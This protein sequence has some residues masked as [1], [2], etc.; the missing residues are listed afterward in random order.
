MQVGD[1]FT[2]G[3]IPEYTYNPRKSFRLEDQIRDYLATGGSVLVITGN[4]KS[5]KSVLCDKVVGENCVNIA[6]G[7]IQKVGDIWQSIVHEMG[8]S[9]NLTI[10]QSQKT[11]KTIDVTGQ[12]G[13][14]FGIKLGTESKS[15][16][17]Q[18]IETA[19]SEEKPISVQRQA[20][21]GL[22]QFK[23]VLVIDDF[24]YLQPNV[25]QY[26]IRALKEP[27]LRGLRVIF[28]AV[29]HKTYDIVRGEREMT[30]RVRSLK[31]PNWT[32]TELKE[33]ALTGFP[34]LQMH[35][36]QDV[37]D[38]FAMESFESPNLMQQF[39]LNFCFSFNIRET[40][41]DILNFE[42]PSEKI[43]DFFHDIIKQNV[44]SDEFERLAAGPKQHG[45][46]RKEY[47][48]KS[49]KKLDLYKGILL[50]ISKTGPKNEISL[51]EL[52]D[53]LISMIVLSKGEK[54]PQSSNLSSVLTQMSNIAKKNA[55]KGNP[56]IDWEKDTSKLFIIDPYFLFYLKWGI[57]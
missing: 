15:S 51:Q 54:T 57:N 41:K 42:L 26:I 56:V 4:T 24:H 23:R 39:C 38:R 55:D 11:A 3:K 43:T 53:T 50:A 30:G 17:V 33:I 25:Q 22:L 14:D 49:D 9:G 18:E 46:R 6:G 40:L 29:P 44:D 1:V 20:I 21:N 37:I 10:Q 27:L 32:P 5:G 36:N 52:R 7:N 19:K 47:L 28:I 31:I 8:L 35:V 34:L 13:I 2:P 45:Q 48:F 16:S 12:A